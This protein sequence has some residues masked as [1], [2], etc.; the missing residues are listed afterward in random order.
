MRPE[1]PQVGAHR[2]RIAVD[3]IP[4]HVKAMERLV[5]ELPLRARAIGHRLTALAAALFAEPNPVVIKGVLHAQ[6]LIPSPAVRLP[7]LPAS[8]E[9]VQAAV[10]LAL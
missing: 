2:V 4:G 1:V 5:P 7:L 10:S 6:G 3:Q 8:P 9:A